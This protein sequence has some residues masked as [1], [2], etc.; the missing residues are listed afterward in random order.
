[1]FDPYLSRIDS[2]KSVMQ[3][4]AHQATTRIDKTTTQIQ[5]TVDSIQRVYTEKA[6]QLF[7]KWGLENPG[8]AEYHGQLIE[9][10]DFNVPA[11]SNQ[12][13]EFTKDFNLKN[14]WPDL[15]MGDF[16][17]DDLQKMNLDVQRR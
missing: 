8:M 4:Q 7:Q 9:K 3:S 14:V 12:Y 2:L 6:Q 5:T 10:M 16:K 11:V 15:K 13:P 1:L 17:L